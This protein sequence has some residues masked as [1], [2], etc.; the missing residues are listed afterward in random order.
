MKICNR[1]LITIRPEQESN[2]VQTHPLVNSTFALWNARSLTRKSSSVCDTILSRKV[3]IMIITETWFKG[4]S[5]DSTIIADINN[6]L[7][8]HQIV[9][10]PRST[11]GGGVCAILK[12]GYCVNRMS[13]QI[14]RSFEHLDLQVASGSNHLRILIVYRPPPSKKNKQSVPMFLEEF[15]TLLETLII[16]PGNLI[17]SGDFNFHFDNIPNDHDATIF[18]DLLQSFGLMQHVRRQAYTQAWT[19]A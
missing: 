2:S 14:F 7:P 13:T 1:T 9:H 12:K 6:C 15:S 19:L 4:D 10:Q 17:I 18:M 3:D 8:D 16:S 5:R 11:R